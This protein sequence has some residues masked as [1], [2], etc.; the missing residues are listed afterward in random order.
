MIENAMTKNKEL[1]REEEDEL[2]K[3]KKKV[4]EGHC[5]NFNEGL[6]ESGHSQGG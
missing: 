2:S 3:S 1:S 6:S 4:K 5:A